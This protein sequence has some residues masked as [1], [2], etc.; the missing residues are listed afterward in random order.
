MEIAAL[1]TARM[2]SVRIPRK[3]HAVIGGYPLWLR[4]AMFAR[5]CGIR[6][7]VD[8]DD[9]QILADAHVSGYETH[10][11]TVLPESAGGSHWDALHGA[12]HDLRLEHYILLQP[13]SPFRSA[14]VLHECLKAH[15][16]QPARPVLTSDDGQTWDGNIGIFHREHRAMP[17]LSDCKFVPNEWYYS[18]Q[19]DFE[20][21][22]E[23]C[24]KMERELPNG[25]LW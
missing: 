8:S 22:I 9:V 16:A 24:R 18:V 21:D 11:R 17:R 13:T 19:I 12:A 7:I 2:D 23:A 6:A 1:I 25:G 4:S 3:N 5:A 14:A 20:Q 15:E 10:V